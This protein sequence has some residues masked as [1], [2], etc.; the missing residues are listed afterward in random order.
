VNNIVVP[1]WSTPLYI[2]S[3]PIASSFVD[4]LESSKWDDITN[5]YLT[6]NTKILDSQGWEEFKT[7]VENHLRIYAK[8]ILRIKNDVEFAITNSWGIKHNKNHWADKHCHSNSLLSGII[9][10]KCNSDSGNI[11]FYKN[12][13]ITTVFPNCFEFD[14]DEYN[15]FNSTS[16]TLTPEENQI[17]I[18]PSHL[19]H[20]V[21]LSESDNTRL[22]ISFNTFIKGKLSN[23]TN[24]N[25]SDLEIK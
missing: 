8:D 14:Y 9:Y 11:N 3:I 7:E 15:M 20:S 17:L 21:N 13:G 18:F 4:S 19:D 6:V 23:I 12:Q 16:H 2:G 22:A 5:G 10:L 24:N 25:L 1:L